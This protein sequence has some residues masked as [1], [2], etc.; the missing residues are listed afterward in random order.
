MPIEIGNN[1]PL[2]A[3]TPSKENA[4]QKQPHAT[5]PS[6]NPSDSVILDKAIELES[7]TSWE[8]GTFIDF[9]I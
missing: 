3:I 6:N 1:W 5:V 9:Y 4:L 8:K 2:M 7:N